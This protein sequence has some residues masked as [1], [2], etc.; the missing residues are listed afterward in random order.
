VPG[1]KID[2]VSFDCPTRGTIALDS[3]LQGFEDWTIDMCDSQLVVALNGTDVLTVTRPAGS[4]SFLQA[5]PGKIDI[6]LAAKTAGIIP[7]EGTSHDLTVRR[8][9]AKCDDR[10]WG[11]ADFT[12][13]TATLNWKNPTL[14]ARIS[15]PAQ[16]ESGVPTPAT[17]TVA[18]VDQFGVPTRFAGIDI[19]LVVSGGTA[20]HTAGTTDAN[21]TFSTT[22]TASGPSA[23]K[24]GTAGGGGVTILAAVSSIEGATDTASASAGVGAEGTA[25]VLL[26]ER[27]VT[28]GASSGGVTEPSGQDIISD[29]TSGVFSTA[30]TAELTYDQDGITFEISSQASQASDI[31]VENGRLKRIDGSSL[32]ST[33]SVQSNVTVNGRGQSS[34]YVRFEVRGAPMPYTLTADGEGTGNYDY[35]ISLIEPFGEVLH[36][37]YFSNSTPFTDINV[38]GSLD[39]GVYNLHLDSQSGLTCFGE[40]SGWGGTTMNFVFTIGTP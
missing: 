22:I 8:R 17:V 13:V 39:P 3:L 35:V 1:G 10:L 15:Y 33:Y 18:V 16:V 38:S 32:F 12:L 40:C 20:A 37:Y 7:R 26:A 4:S 29:A 36:R 30:G 34:V 23:L 9:R 27:R 21:G 2:A 24:R 6:A 25:V 11:Q 5:G 28:A 19:T 14:D 31:V